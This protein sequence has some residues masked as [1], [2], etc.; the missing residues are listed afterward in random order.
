MG[1]GEG[2]SGRLLVLTRRPS[3]LGQFDPPKREDLVEV[4]IRRLSREKRPGKDCT[5]NAAGI[6]MLPTSPAW[7]G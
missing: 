5:Q 6:L 7:A 1:A 4:Q 3:R 2:K